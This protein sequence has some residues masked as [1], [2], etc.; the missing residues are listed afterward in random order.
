M[1]EKQFMYEV[2]ERLGA[3]R[4]T[5]GL[6]IRCQVFT[7]NNNT[8][9][10]GIVLQQDNERVTPMIFLEHYY[11]NYL[12]EQMSVDETVKQIMEMLEPVKKH[13]RQYQSLSL[14]FAE[15]QDKI[16]YRLISKEMNENLCEK[17]PYIPFLD[18]MISFCV[19]VN[20]SDSGVETI[21]VTNDLMNEWGVTT[22]ELY[23][24]AEEN[25]PRIFPAK[26]QFLSELL[27]KHL[28]LPDQKETSDELKIPMIIM[29]NEAGVYGASTILYPNAVE[30]IANELNANLY[31]LPSS[32]HEFIILPETDG[33]SLDEL[34]DMVQRI[35]KDYVKEEEILSDQAYFYNK[36]QK[37]FI[38]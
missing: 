2:A 27:Q 1:T 33:N 19:V 28:E 3:L 24:L 38:F 13:A 5:K 16:I 20:Y 22:S 25:T 29:G 37:K 23:R 10:Y 17:I 11:E 32:V 9:H 18:L 36:N 12:Q 35:N 26:I 14:Q 30:H 34:A 4:Q 31:I 8:K 6:D 15:C 7:K 21:K